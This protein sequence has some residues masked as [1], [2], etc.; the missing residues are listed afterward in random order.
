VV[1]GEAR[2]VTGRE[3]K[4]R[5]LECLVEHVLPGRSADARGPSDAEL[6]VT[7]VVALGLGH[8][9]AKVRTGPPVDSRAD[10]SL[11]VWAGELP[12]RLAVG[13]PAPDAHCSAP[14]PSALREYRR[15]AR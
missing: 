8:A 13:E 15:G 14:E 9:S 3:E 2:A 10:L 11:P 12:L 6:K 7:E 5:A 4:L 1:V